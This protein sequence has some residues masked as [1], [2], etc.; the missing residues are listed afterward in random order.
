MKKNSYLILLLAFVIVSCDYFYYSP[1]KNEGSIA[2]VNDVY[3]YK[4]DIVRLVPKG[5]SKADSIAFVSTLVNRWAKQQLLEQGAEFNL[6]PKRL[7]EFDRL[8]KQYRSD[9]Y[10]KAYLEA[11]VNKNLD[12]LVGRKEAF[13]YYKKNMEAFR[14]NENLINLRYVSVSR[15]RKDVGKIT[16]AFKRYN[17][18]DMGLLDSLSIHFKSYS[19]RRSLWIR[20]SQAIA[21]IPVLTV[22]DVN[23]LT[24]E[25]NYIEL[26]D[27]THVYLIHINNVLKRNNIAP[28]EYVRP[29]INQIILNKRKLDLIENL[30]SEIEEDAIKNKQFEIY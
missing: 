27:K 22:K 15:K 9:L 26:K 20:A 21:R 11:L 12:T 17:G 13:N 2:R 25:S 5:I 16:K 19:L 7:E 6:N 29:T 1:R 28:L 23:E 4:K 10:S 18:R 3:L 30:E 8:A 24:K 14:L